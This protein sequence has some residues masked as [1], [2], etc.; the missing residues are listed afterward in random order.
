VQSIKVPVLGCH[1]NCGG[2]GCMSSWVLITPWCGMG[3]CS[4][5]RVGAA[6]ILVGLAEV[7]MVLRDMV[8]SHNFSPA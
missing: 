6:H 3:F 2:V 5:T 7:Q 4:T 1:P 8:H